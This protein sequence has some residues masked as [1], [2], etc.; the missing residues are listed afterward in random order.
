MASTPTQPEA[1]QEPAGAAPCPITGRPPKRRI[2]T[3]SSRLIAD[4]WRYG[5]GIDV[6]GLLRD[7][8]TVRLYESDTG[9][10]YFS[11]PVVG[12]AAFYQTYYKRKD[13]HASLTVGGETRVDFA[14][15]ARHVKPGDR[16]IDVGCGPAL[17]RHHVPQAHYTGLDPYA[18]DDGAGIILH[19]T[20]ENHALT[21]AGQY[22]VATAFHV[23]EHVADPLRHAALMAAL[24]KPGGLLILAAPLHPSP[25]TEIPNMPI[26][27]PPHHVTWWNPDAFSALAAQLGLDVVEASRLAASPHHAPML[28]IHK[29]LFRKTDH[30]PPGERYF[31]GKMSWNLSVWLAYMMAG[32]AQRFQAAPTTTRPVDSLLVARKNRRDQTA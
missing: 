19:D 6:R 20:L 14:S 16:V 7:V 10:V 12:D 9:L 28:W 15:A 30:T 32:V 29:L 13:V 3:L 23:I 18:E 21:H 17:F 31:S 1:T 2:Q 4:I 8:T 25:W 22:D 5:Q 24:L 11:P 27:M 26:N